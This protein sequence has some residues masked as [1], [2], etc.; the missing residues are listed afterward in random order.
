MGVSG[1]GKTTVG[2]LLAE[3][4]GWSYYDGDDFHSR[5]NIKKMA[6]GLALNDGDRSLW[7]DCITQHIRGLVEKPQNAVLS[8]SALKQQFRKQL[9][10]DSDHIGFVYLKGSM[11]LI[12]ERLAVRQGH[13]FNADLLRSQFA[14][15]E[16]PCDVMTADISQSPTQIS[17]LI[18]L[19]FGL[20]P[21]CSS[22]SD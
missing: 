13:F 16:E 15:L 9:L 21:K 6:N 18:Q 22:T 7:L 14:I 20:L 11:G 1:S 19:H 3:N 5:E 12:K 4:L 8:C 10:L 2:R 17:K